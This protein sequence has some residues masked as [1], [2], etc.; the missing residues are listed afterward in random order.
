VIVRNLEFAD[1]PRL[2]E[3]HAA[4]GL[5]YEFPNLG[6]SLYIVKKVVE[7]DGTVV[8]AA[9]AR[10][11]VEVSVLC[12]AEWLT[13]AF[14]LKAFELLHEEM[15]RELKDKGLEDCHAWIPPQMKNFARRLMRSF[16]WGKSNWES[17]ER[18]L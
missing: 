18:T 10:L 4:S 13:P 6:N 9:A 7:D 8:V 12:D 3:I 14:R 11:T 1:E 2:R 5:E 17:Y 15:R 16:G